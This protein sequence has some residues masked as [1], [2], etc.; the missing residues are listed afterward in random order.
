MNYQLYTLPNCEK[1][2]EIKEFLKRKEI[3][4]EEINI[5]SGNGRTKFNEVYKKIRERIK[6]DKDGMVELPIIIGSND[7]KVEII[8][9][10]FGI[11]EL[12]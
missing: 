9:Q 7:S 12:F 11:K 2:A 5:A 6:R 3:E 4:Y 1:C 8:C 10:S